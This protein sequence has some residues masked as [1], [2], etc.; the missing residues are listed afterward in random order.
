M[1]RHKQFRIN[2]VLLCG[3]A[4]L[5]L[6]AGIVSASATTTNHYDW[7]NPGGSDPKACEA[8]CRGM[9][10]G[11]TH[12]STEAWAQCF[13]AT[14][15]S[16]DG[17]GVDEQACEQAHKDCDKHTAGISRCGSGYRVCVDACGVRRE[18]ARAAPAPLPDEYMK[19]LAPPTPEAKKKRHKAKQD[20]D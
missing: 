19:S 5:M 14:S 9:Y 18:G 16:C 10:D 11:C 8:S 20:I 12:E 6:A 7:E 1:T 15:A 13:G 4:L 2:A 17:P 3:A